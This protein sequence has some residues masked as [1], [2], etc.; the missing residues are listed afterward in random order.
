MSKK[1]AE[2]S[3]LRKSLDKSQWWGAGEG[4]KGVGGYTA[5]SRNSFSTL[6][7]NLR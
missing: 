1:S 2:S 5:S 6:K 4:G 3:S 7:N